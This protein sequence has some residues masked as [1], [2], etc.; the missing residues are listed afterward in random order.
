MRIIDFH[1]DT[2]MKMYDLHKVG[3]DSQSVWKN[4]CQIDVQ[5]LVEA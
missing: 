1:C 2:L 5:R 3:D 4:E